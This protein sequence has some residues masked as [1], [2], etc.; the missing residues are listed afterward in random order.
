MTSTTATRNMPDE[1]IDPVHHD[2]GTKAGEGE[3]TL[4]KFLAATINFAASDLIVKVDLPPRIR[5]RGSLKSLQTERC[6]EQLMFQ[7][8]KDV[9]DEKQYAYSSASPC[10]LSIHG[11]FSDLPVQQRWTP[12][13]QMRLHMHNS[14]PCPPPCL[15][16]L[17]LS[18]LL[19]AP[20]GVIESY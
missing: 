3:R 18:P 5:L 12:T 20:G 4:Q 13:I 14:V 8:A 11:P 16:P 17:V 6:S 10:H 9:L 15:N 19:P 2:L 1:T 7:I